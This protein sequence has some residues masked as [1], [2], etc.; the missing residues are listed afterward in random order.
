MHEL[1]AARGAESWLA[2]LEAWRE[3]LEARHSLH[4]QV[5]SRTATSAGSE[6]AVNG[7]A[8]CRCTK[9]DLMRCRLDLDTGKM[10]VTVSL[11][12]ICARLLMGLRCHPWSS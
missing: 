3:G 4:L 11:Q 1:N 7:D 2:N 9:A 6:A 10:A 5:L 8:S 12:N